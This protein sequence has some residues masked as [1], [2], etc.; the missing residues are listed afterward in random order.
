[1]YSVQQ[2]RKRKLFDVAID[3][4]DGDDVCSRSTL[5]PSGIVRVSDE[6]IASERLLDSESLSHESLSN[7]SLVQVAAF[8]FDGTCI[9]GSSPKKLVSW[10]I[11]HGFLS[12]YKAFRICCWGLAYKM[13]LPKDAEGVRERVFSAFK[14]F[15]AIKVNDFLCRFYHQSIAELYRP[16]ADAAMVA[17]LEAGHVVVLVSASFEPMIAA[18]MTDHPIQFA[19]ASRMHIDGNGDYT[20]EI[21]GL[22]TEGPDKI[23]VLNKFLNEYFGEGRWNLGWAYGDHYS[24]LDMLKAADNPCAVTPDGKLRRLATKLGW[25]ILEWS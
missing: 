4:V 3:S 14:G 2:A 24:D 10:L 23:V 8:D 12:S 11:R 7:E 5:L 6:A 19:L 13:N 21:E 22:P 15:S 1:M 16:D 9:N 20:N 25:T 18:A 17:H